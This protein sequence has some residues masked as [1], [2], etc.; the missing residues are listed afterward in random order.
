MTIDQE[1][2]AINKEISDL[3]ESISKLHEK[4]FPLEEKQRKIIVSEIIDKK[5]LTDSMWE[6]EP[7]S[8]GS[9]CLNYKGD[10]EDP[11]MAPIANLSKNHWY[12]PYDLAEGVELRLDNS[13]ITLLFDDPKKIPRFMAT[14]KITV[15][16]VG[17]LN[18]LRELRREIS[19]LEMICHQLELKG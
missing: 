19:A 2:A 1:L 14:F 11:I 8:G 13:Y 12:H 17:I 3:D 10:I 7:Y 5:M 6:I 16:G 18:R 15:D 4:S 9:I